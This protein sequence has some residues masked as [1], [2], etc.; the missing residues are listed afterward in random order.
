MSYYSGIAHAV[1]PLAVAA[2]IALAAASAF[3]ARRGAVVI[4]LA[5]NI[6]LTVPPFRPEAHRWWAAA[7]ALLL[8]VHLGRAARPKGDVP[9]GVLAQPG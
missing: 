2:L 3:P 9:G 6:A 4:A 7:A 5:T 8:L 1:L